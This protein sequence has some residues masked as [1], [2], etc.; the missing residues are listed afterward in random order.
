MWN[1]FL[2][3]ECFVKHSEILFSEGTIQIKWSGTMSHQ[4]TNDCIL[5][6]DLNLSLE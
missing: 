6:T 2:F 1:D 3:Q 4:N 5:K